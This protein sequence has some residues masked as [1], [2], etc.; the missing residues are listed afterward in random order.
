MRQM[1]P[2]GN[3]G[4]ASDNSLEEIVRITYGIR[5]ALQLY[6]SLLSQNP[7]LSGETCGSRNGLVGTAALLSIAALPDD[8]AAHRT[9]TPRSQIEKAF[10]P[11]NAPICF[12]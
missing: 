4:L 5:R 7:Y 1:D 6:V 8:W 11:P 2:Q 10:G 12:S 9:L 3:L